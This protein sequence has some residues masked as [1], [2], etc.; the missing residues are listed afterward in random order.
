MLW[1]GTV[2]LILHPISTIVGPQLDMRS[3]SMEHKSHGV[4]GYIQL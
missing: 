3:F 1:L 4:V 2:T